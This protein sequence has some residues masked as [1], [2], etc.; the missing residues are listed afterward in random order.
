MSIEMSPFEKAMFDAVVEEAARKCSEDWIDRRTRVLCSIVFDM[1]LIAGSMLEKE[2]ILMPDDSREV[3]DT[4][5]NMAVNML[6]EIES[7][8][9]NEDGD[10]MEKIATVGLKTRFGK[11]EQ[12]PITPENADERIPHLQLE[13]VPL[14]NDYDVSDW[15]LWRVESEEELE[16]LQ[17]CI[18]EPD[19][20]ANEFIPDGYPCVV[21]TFINDGGYGE[22]CSADDAMK[23]FM[24]YAASIAKAKEKLTMEVNEK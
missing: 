2:A 20:S 6:D 8:K 10:R 9:E 19:A 23:T 24:N 12:D 17:S 21:F 16:A 1:T 18:Y 13:G 14:T 3:S 11:P 15:K 5:R 22:M 4:I 7:N